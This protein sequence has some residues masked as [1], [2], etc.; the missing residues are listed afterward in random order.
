[1]AA[2]QRCR[3]YQTIFGKAPSGWISVVPEAY[4]IFFFISV[5]PANLY[6]LT[7]LALAPKLNDEEAAASEPASARSGAR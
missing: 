2:D 7:V 6:L 1:L 5:V 3:K 4:L